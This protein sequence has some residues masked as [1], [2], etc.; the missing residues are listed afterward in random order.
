MNVRQQLRRW[1]IWL[2]WIVG[3]PFLAWTVS[4]L[5]MVARPIEVVRGT[6]LLGP[7][8]ALPSGLVPVP[9]AVGARPV[10]S[11]ALEQRPQG[12]RWIVRYQDGAARLADAA[13]GR[14]LPPLA[15]AEAVR[16]VEARYA[17]KARVAAV[18][19][20]SAD[21]PPL[22]LR[23]KIETWRVTMDDDTRFY[24]NAATGEIVATRTAWWRV[25]DLMWG[26]HIMDLET[27]EDTS[28]PLVIGF[29]IIALVTTLLALVMLPLT[30]RRRRRGR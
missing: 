1:H 6:D 11:M 16:L 12:P 18:D 20:T 9:P 24:V 21:D 3:L 13:T 14:L 27:R 30:I 8:P 26:L 22:E 7:A 17:G 28:N 29:G 2:G 19:R 15:A 23:R 5:V 25:F 4:G 10:A